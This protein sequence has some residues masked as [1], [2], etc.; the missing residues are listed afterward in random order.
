MMTIWKPW[1]MSKILTIDNNKILNLIIVDDDDNLKSLGIEKV[2]IINKNVIIK[3]PDGQTIFCKFKMDNLDGT[4]QRL[5][6]K[7]IDKGI[8]GRA[9]ERLELLLTDKILQRIDEL[10][11][12]KEDSA[13]TTDIPT[14]KE[15]IEKDR[16]S[17]GQISAEEW[18]A[19]LV[20]K[21]E[22]L[23][24]TVR[25]NLPNLRSGLEFVLSAKSILKIKDC[26]LPFAG[27]LLGSPSSLKTVGIELFRKWPQTYYT[28]NF[29][30][31]SFVSHST[32]VTKEQLE[33]IDNAA[34]DTKQSFPNSGAGP[35]ICSKR[36]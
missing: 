19:K 16:I 34:K 31:K 28:D 26:T 17:I 8:N 32:A 14:I 1:E 27:I 30:A 33:E 9:I 13:S 22:N 10:E 4:L 3:L 15:E 11:G 18:Q 29:S 21:Y 25:L 35:H 23:Q 2:S 5:N 12:Q 24:E 36:R 20:E 6:K 7:L